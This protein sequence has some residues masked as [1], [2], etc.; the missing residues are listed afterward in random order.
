MCVLFKFCT[1]GSPFYNWIFGWKCRCCMPW[2]FSG[3]VVPWLGL[4]FSGPIVPWLGLT[5]ISFIAILFFGGFRTRT[6]DW[7]FGDGKVSHC[8]RYNLN[9]LSYSQSTLQHC[10]RSEFIILLFLV[11][12]VLFR[13]WLLIF[14]SLIDHLS[15]ST[16]YM[17][18]NFGIAHLNEEH[19][20]K[21]T[22]NKWL[23]V[24]PLAIIIYYKC[25]HRFWNWSLSC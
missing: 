20:L 6:Q 8:F 16:A 23:K 24:G 2:A 12:F 4:T 10:S 15:S 7:G 22:L 5:H 3:P 13:E 19:Y 1:R 11:V 14:S 9:N 25:R 21:V 17:H 18:V